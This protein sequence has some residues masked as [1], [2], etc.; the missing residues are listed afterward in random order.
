MQDPSK[1]VDDDSLKLDE[2]ATEQAKRIQEIRTQNIQDASKTF[3]EVE[4]AKDKIIDFVTNHMGFSAVHPNT[5]PTA[6]P[7]PFGQTPYQDLDN[8]L[9]KDLGEILKDEDSILRNFER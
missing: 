3:Q 8:P 2:S 6:W 5:N 9:R 7:P 4:E 1:N